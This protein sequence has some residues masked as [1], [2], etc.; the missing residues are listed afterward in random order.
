MSSSDLPAEPVDS[1][2]SS[3]R[4]LLPVFAGLALSFAILVAAEIHG[5]SFARWHSVLDRS[6]P[7]EIL[8]GEARAI[9]ADDW[10]VQLPMAMAQRA[11]APRFPA[12]NTNIGAGLDMRLPIEVPVASPTALFRPGLWGYWLGDDMGIA[13]LWWSQVFG[14]FVA[15]L[16]AFHLLSGLRRSLSIGAALLLTVSPYFQF[17]SFTKASIAWAMAACLA[18]AVGVATA[19]RPAGIVLSGIGLGWAGA[20]FACNLYPPHQVSLAYLFLAAVG[21]WLLVPE[22]RERLRDRFAWR[23]VVVAG[24]GL[25]AALGAA[26]FVWE[27]REAISLITHTAYPG[28]RVSTG[29]DVSWS[30]LFTPHVGAA[31]FVSKWGVLETI[32]SSASFWLSFPLILGALLATRCRDPLAIGLGLV[33]LVWSAYRVFGIPETLARATLVSFVP[34][35]RTTMVIGLAD[36]LLLARWLA[37]A[38]RDPAPRPVVA[39]SLAALWAGVVGT[40]GLALRTDV[41]ELPT[42]AVV[43]GAVLS[44][45]LGYGIARRRAVPAIVLGLAATMGLSSLWFNPLARGGSEFIRENAISRALQEVD[46]AEDGTTRWITYGSSDL[47][48]LPRML[49][50]DSIGGVMSL[51]A[52]DLWSTLD[53]GPKAER[54]YNRYAHVAFRPTPRAGLPPKFRLST[55]HGFFVFLDAEG[56]DPARLGVTHFL[57]R[58]RSS[59]R[60]YWDAFE[61]LVEVDERTRVYALPLDRRAP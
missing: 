28:T 14:V 41:P 10:L 1:L 31:L 9:R 7:D 39:L 42:A 12:I 52:L 15:W 46:A 55:P 2:S 49:G 21:C 56:E 27:S 26:H 11:H 53:S 47:A 38:D 4:P 13:W 44:G 59:T 6:P 54:V 45:G 25:F 61:P 30:S 24:A 36:A 57:V 18:A 60:A 19:R 32:C 48:N 37:L 3:L 17:W 33:C 43:V 34:G 16:L 8:L 40:A 20:V 29:G 58:L 22:H 51:P 35:D 23:V 5:F 50:I